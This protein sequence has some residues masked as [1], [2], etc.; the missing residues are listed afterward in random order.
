M[1]CEG[2]TYEWAINYDSQ[3]TTDDGSCIP[4]VEGCWDSLYL[5]YNS[6][7]NVDNGS[8]TNLILEG[9]MNE[10]AFNYNSEANTDNGSCEF[11]C[12]FPSSWEYVTTG[13]NHTMMIPQ[14]ISIDINGHPLT[15]GSSIGV[16][17]TNEN[18]EL[19]C[20]GYTQINGEQAFIAIM[21]DDSTTDEFDGFQEGEQITWMVWDILTC[22]EYQVNAS[23]SNGS[24]HIQQ[25]L[26]HSLNL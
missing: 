11:I 22:Q 6:E 25:M 10:T 14:D 23:Y 15:Q 5:E 12:S 21:G 26:F 19:Q 7:V 13:S 8:C 4:V 9:C 16:F 2:C 3:A 1:L 17:Y 20:A 24:Q 18:G